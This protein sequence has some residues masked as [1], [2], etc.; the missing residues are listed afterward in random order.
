LELITSENRFW[1][2]CGCAPVVMRYVGDLLGADV[3][4]WQFGK[5]I[6]R[7][8]HTSIMFVRPGAPGDGHEL[9]VSVTPDESGGWNLQHSELPRRSSA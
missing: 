4:N 1:D 8:G 9:W 5:A 2:A 7:T 6:V 3:A